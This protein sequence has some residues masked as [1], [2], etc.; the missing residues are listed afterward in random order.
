[1]SGS[2]QGVWSDLPGNA[3][4]LQCCL[5]GRMKQCQLT[6]RFL[7]AAHFVAR[8]AVARLSAVKWSST[9]AGADSNAASARHVA[10]TEQTPVAP[11]TVDYTRSQS[12]YT[13][14]ACSTAPA[15]T[16]QTDD[17]RNCDDRRRAEKIR[18]GP[19]CRPSERPP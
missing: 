4:P 1:M 16:S 9:F 10:A 3:T 12:A 14:H 19:P 5:N 13:H 11:D 18:T 6:A 2:W 7:V 15:R 17:R 8:V